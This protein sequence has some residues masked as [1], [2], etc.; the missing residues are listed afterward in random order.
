MILLQTVYVCMSMHE[1]S[2]CSRSSLYVFMSFIHIREWNRKCE[3]KADCSFCPY[4][5]KVSYSFSESPF[6]SHLNQDHGGQHPWGVTS[7]P[8]TR[9]RSTENG[10]EIENAGR[11]SAEKSGCVNKPSPDTGTWKCGEKKTS[12]YHQCLSSCGMRKLVLDQVLDL[13]S[14]DSLHW[15]TQDYERNTE[16]KPRAVR[17]DEKASGGSKVEP[18]EGALWHDKN[19]REGIAGIFCFSVLLV[20]TLWKKIANEF[21]RV[22]KCVDKW[23]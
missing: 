9:G 13:F 10:W 7:T 20:K 21:L 18:R 17:Q 11:I 16:R 3:T 6:L 23:N 5:L 14:V 12:S 15:W 19:A 22:I 8:N 4:S 1:T 2:L